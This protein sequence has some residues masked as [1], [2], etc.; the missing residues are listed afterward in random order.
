MGV[1]FFTSWR[2]W[3]LSTW[4]NFLFYSFLQEAEEEKKYSEPSYFTSHTFSFQFFL[5]PFCS[6]T[7]NLQ[8]S[9]QERL[10]APWESLYWAYSEILLIS[11]HSIFYIFIDL[12]LHMWVEVVKAGLLKINTSLCRS[13]LVAPAIVNFVTHVQRICYCYVLCNKLFRNNWFYATGQ[14]V[15]NAMLR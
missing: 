12:E 3:G 6:G 11:D 4:E 8:G 1:F 2:K 5:V 13:W 7:T 15:D 10:R 9:R 14:F